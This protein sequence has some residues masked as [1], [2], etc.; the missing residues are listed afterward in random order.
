MKNKIDFSSTIEE[1]KE[2]L[3]YK[4]EQ[5]FWGNLE[6][7]I[8]NLKQLVWMEDE[9]PSVLIAG[10]MVAFDKG[11][12]HFLNELVKK[13]FNN[14]YILLSEV[15]AEFRRKTSM[16]IE[17]EHICTPHLLAKEI[18]VPYMDITIT[19]EI[20]EYVEKEQYL[21]E[22]I[23]NLESRHINMGK[24]YAQ[25][26]VYYADIYLRRLIDVIKPKKV[27]LWNEFYALHSV[28]RHICEMQGIEIQ[29]ME[30]GCI[31]G[32][33]AL[34]KDGQQGESF[35]AR[36]PLKF[37][38]LSVTKED[39]EGA[40]Q[41]VAYVA[42]EQL[43]RNVQPPW[44]KVKQ[45][46]IKYKVQGPIVTYMGQ[47]DY[48]SGMYPY[49]K[50]AKK[51]HSPIFESTLK[52]LEYLSILSLKNGWNLV[53]KP[54]PII[55]NLGVEK[56]DRDKIDCT[57]ALDVN[58]HELID[59]SDVIITI[60]SQA[61]YL[62]LFR[63]K[64]VVLLGYMQLSRS[65]CVYDAYRK[66]KIEIQIKNAIKKGYTEIQK[67]NFYKHVARQVKYCLYD[68][69]THPDFRFGKEL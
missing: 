11:T 66:G 56:R 34:E 42:N 25:T 17:F 63:Q 32:T 48:E 6:F 38:C 16:C 55:E 15:T 31:P 50:N 39:I 52:G 12:I 49:N 35:P 4:S 7:G 45:N 46:I 18:V 61:A 64:P 51:Y 36:H 57:L 65:G 68:D 26:L 3:A 60:L 33:I 21:Q 22:A 53:Y 23:Q 1:Q 9:R 30:F 47:N 43:N 44:G 14:R 69:L 24:G 41:V 37:K 10:A 8:K 29:Y 27:I 13:D 40:K 28:L 54:H 67:Q 2:Y 5:D 58:I 59:Y 19:E 62:S 20:V